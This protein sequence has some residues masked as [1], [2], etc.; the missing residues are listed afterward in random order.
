LLIIHDAFINATKTGPLH[1]AE[2][3]CLLMHSTQ[4]KCYSTSEYAALLEEAGFTPGEY[5]DTAV[6]RGFMTATRRHT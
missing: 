6:A 2:Y 3:S 4:G 5:L 1:V